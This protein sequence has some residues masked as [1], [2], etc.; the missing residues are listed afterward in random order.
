MGKGILLIQ[1]ER[2]PF[3]DRNKGYRSSMKEDLLFFSQ[4]KID[5]PC[6]REEISLI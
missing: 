2:S 1:E 3:S 4:K 5:I 6:A